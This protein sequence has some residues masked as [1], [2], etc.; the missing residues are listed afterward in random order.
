MRHRLVVGSHWVHIICAPVLE[1]LCGVEESGVDQLQLDHVN[2][3]ELLLD[4]LQRARTV[5]N[6]IWMSRLSE[7]HQQSKHQDVKEMNIC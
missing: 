6:A 3:V 4:A 1:E 7:R 5:R 2:N